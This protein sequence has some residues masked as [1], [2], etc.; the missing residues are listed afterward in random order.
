MTAVTTSTRMPADPPAAPAEPILAAVL[1]HAH[2]RFFVVAGSQVREIEC[3][4]SPRMRGGKFHSDRQG[5]PGWGERGFHGRRHEEERRHYAAVARR[6][7]G[8]VR[9]HGAEGVVIGGSRR[10]VAEFREALSPTLARAV[11][12]VALLN[13]TA[14]SVDAVRRAVRAARDTAE[15]AEQR[16]WVAALTEGFGKGRAVEGIR[17]VLQ[18]LDRN[19]VRVLLVAQ[20]QARVGYRGARTGRLILSKDEAAGEASVRVPNLIAAVVEEARRRRAPVIEVRERRL[21][22][23]FDGI[24]ALLRYR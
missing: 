13:V 21:A 3:L 5:S 10:V 2:A 12:G 24:A 1:D 23:R 22:A 8:L 11:L 19:Q 15:L 9:A 7:G 18:A 17:P 14:V 4:T 20:D 6:L 16:A